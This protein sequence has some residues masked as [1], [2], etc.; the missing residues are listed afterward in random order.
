MVQRHARSP[1]VPGAYVFPGGTVREDDR[2][3]STTSRFEPLSNRSDTPLDD[4]EAAALYVCAV[5]EL[6]EEAGVLLV[7]NPDGALLSVD[8]AETTRQERLESARLALQAGEISIGSLLTDNGWQ[9]AFDWLAPFSHWVTP[10]E[11]QA[12]FDTRF[13]VAQMPEG[14]LALHD[15]IETSEGLWLTP[16]SALEPEYH[17]VY[18][19]EQHLR[20]LAPFQTVSAL[21]AF[22]RTKPIRMV[23]PEIVVESEFRRLTIRADI[24]DVW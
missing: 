10:R 5:R 21:L 19:T 7:R 23:Q 24:A 6:F 8:P 3:V 11:V 22:A 4:A 14:Q 2:S 12:R 15:T 20:R 17:T 13:F 18:P 9:P 16:S 1:V